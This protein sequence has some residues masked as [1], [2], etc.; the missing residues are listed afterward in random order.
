MMVPAAALGRTGVPG[1]A[2]GIP[3]KGLAV[4]WRRKSRKMD[5][6]PDNNFL[7]EIAGFWFWGLE[8]V[9]EAMLVCETG[10]VLR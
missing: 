5:Q 6:E 9:M 2:E 4:T 7:R 8:H 1:K 3:E 10:E